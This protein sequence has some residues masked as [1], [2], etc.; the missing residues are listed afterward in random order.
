MCKKVASS[1]S[2]A[3]SNTS[4]A[5]KCSSERRVVFSNS[6][7]N[8]SSDDCKFKDSM[9]CCNRCSQSDN[10]T[11]HTNYCSSSSDNI[12]RH[13]YSSNNDKCTN[14][15]K[16]CNH[17][18]PILFLLSLFCETW[19]HETPYWDGQRGG[20]DCNFDT[21]RRNLGRVC[22]VYKRSTSNYLVTPITAAEGK[23][24]GPDSILGEFGVIRMFFRNSF[25]SM[26]NLFNRYQN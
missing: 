1:N 10:C 17:L 5:M 19:A 24:I 20:P 6:N 14:F 25:V 22:A 12:D 18:V 8:S 9:P 15:P 7:S 23:A 2:V 3:A 26:A 13:S 11:S 4:V 16:K 21:I